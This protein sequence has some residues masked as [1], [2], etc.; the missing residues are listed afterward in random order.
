MEWRSSFG[1]LGKALLDLVYPP[2]CPACKVLLPQGLD[3]GDFCGEC[4]SRLVPVEPP[5]CEMCA[6][7]FPGEISGPFR[8]PN[9]SGRT[10]AFDFTVCL[11]LSRGPVREVIH[12]L[13]YNGIPAMRL[14]LARLMLPAFQDPRLAGHDWLLVPVPL[15]PR[16]RRE[17]RFNQSAELARMITRLGGPPVREVLRRTRYT[18][19]QAGQDREARLQNLRGAFF[20]KSPLP[21]L[22]SGAGGPAHR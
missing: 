22:D 10:V 1:K 20:G 15:H 17:R 9:C 16:K 13:K 7:P 5:F 21:F 2:H 12:R 14:P 6:E 3:A 8:C 18:S 11:W 19:S 4:D